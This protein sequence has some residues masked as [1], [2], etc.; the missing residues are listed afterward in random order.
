MIV[1]G[2]CDGHD[3]GA[4]LVKDGEVLAALSEERITGI[5]R[6]PGFPY[7]SIARIMRLARI[8]PED[9]DKV[10]V[11]EVF[12]RSIHRLLNRFYIK[13]NPNLPMNRPGNALSSAVQNF[14]ASVPVIRAFDAALSRKIMARRFRKMGFKAPVEMIDHHLAH[15]YCAA[16]GSAFDDCLVVT[17]D[18][19]GDGCTGG[20]WRYKTGRLNAMTRLKYPLSPSLIYG[21]VCSI[22]G[23]NEGEEGQVSALAASGDPLKA[24]DIFKE[25]I[26]FENGRLVLKEAPNAK[27]LAEKLAGFAPE[28]VAARLQ[29]YVEDIVGRF[30]TH[31]MREAKAKKLCL[32]GG[33]FA[34]VRLNQMIAKASG[35]EDLY[36]FPHMGDGGLCVGAAWAANPAQL[37]QEMFDPLLGIVAEEMGECDVSSLDAVIEPLNDA[38]YEKIAAALNEGKAVGIV[39]GPMEFGPRALGCRSILFAADN[40]KTAAQISRVLQRPEI[41]PFAPAVR[42]EDFG[43]FTASPPY[44]AFK[45]MT[46]CADAKS[47]IIDRYPIA[48]H[49][50]G[51]MR[52][53]AARKKSSPILHAILT[54][55][56]AHCSPPI[57]INTSF[58]VHGEP[59]IA[60]TK[61]AYMLFMQSPLTALVAA[62]QCFWKCR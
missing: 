13:T 59:I 14:I 40:P 53:Q 18:A 26:D 19:F 30:I 49:V 1:L 58:N 38:Q 5:K 62:N 6:Q 44:S 39:S 33:I 41:M 51:S 2:V 20:L 12:G 42:A 25:F 4:C 9:V 34:N 54:A 24:K 57:L 22:L 27:R 43:E 28:D 31:W 60:A 32:A 61:R 11:A 37:P 16:Y 47:E 8:K 10:A 21:R 23:F 29:K 56:A 46:V 7:K 55:Y 15:A 36:V 17:M 48:A 52:V 45:N 50:D 35:C 3:A